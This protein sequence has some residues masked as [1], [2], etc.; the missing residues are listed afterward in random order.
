MDLTGNA[1]GLVTSDYF[2]IY[3]KAKAVRNDCTQY[4]KISTVSHV[5]KMYAKFFGIKNETNHRRATFRTTN[6]SRRKIGCTYAMFTFRQL[7]EKHKYNKTCMW[8]L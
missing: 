6:G 2:F 3:R 7:S 5:A 1:N 8:H 4:Q